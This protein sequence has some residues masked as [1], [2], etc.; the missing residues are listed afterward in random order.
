LGP[1]SKSGEAESRARKNLAEHGEP[2][3]GRD[4]RRATDIYQHPSLSPVAEVV[5]PLGWIILRNNWEVE[6]W[7]FPFRKFQAN[8][9]LRRARILLKEGKSGRNDPLDKGTAG[10]KNDGVAS[11]NPKVIQ[12][13]RGLEKGSPGLL[14]ELIDLFLK[15]AGTHLAGLQASFKARDA[16]SFE[17]GAHTLKGSSGNLGAQAMSRIC[18]ELQAIGRAADWGRAPEE[19]SR[20]EEEFRLVRAELEVERARS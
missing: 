8:G 15:E 20:L 19:M 18:G 9:T 16:G 3:E 6:F 17:R 10:S 12:E 1:A 11:L 7:N 4:G 2:G 13:L 14:R 5:T